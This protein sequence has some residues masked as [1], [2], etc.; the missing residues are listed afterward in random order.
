[1]MTYFG[2]PIDALER[3]AGD[4]EA[5]AHV[6]PPEIC[7]AMRYL[8]NELFRINPLYEV[9]SMYCDEQKD[10]LDVERVYKKLVTKPRS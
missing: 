4:I 9:V 6:Y 10:E 5:S 3:L 7:Q 2:E 1:M 8:A